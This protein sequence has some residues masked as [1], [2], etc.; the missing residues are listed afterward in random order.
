MENKSPERNSYFEQENKEF[1]PLS[2]QEKNFSVPAPEQKPQE[3]TIM[4]QQSAQQMPT[5]DTNP[6][7]IQDIA[8][9]VENTRIKSLLD[10]TM[11][12]GVTQALEESRKYNDAYLLDKFH[13]ELVKMR[14]NLVKNKKVSKE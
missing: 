7:S 8:E 4:S 1:N 9:S 2:E 12:N 3:S 11:R 13:N 5:A 6:S 14:E 10:I